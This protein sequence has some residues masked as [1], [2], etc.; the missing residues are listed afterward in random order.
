MVPPSRR[1]PV[2]SRGREDA[3]TIR[4]RAGRRSCPRGRHS[5]CCA[6]AAALTTARMTALRPGASPPPVRTP[7]R[8]SADMCV[9]SVAGSG[10]C[11]AAA[12]TCMLHSKFSWA[13]SSAGRAP[14]SQ[15]G[16]QEFD[17]PAVHHMF[18]E[19]RRLQP[20]RLFSWPSSTFIAFINAP[21]NPRSSFS[22]TLGCLLAGRRLLTKRP[23]HQA[24]GP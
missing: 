8:E 13:A 12:E 1:M 19:A 15:R 16:G 5:G 23:T 20:P 7:M 3:R 14:R 21:T 11:V 2:T 6:F 4:L 18:R 22:G 24:D 10:R 17:P 9:R